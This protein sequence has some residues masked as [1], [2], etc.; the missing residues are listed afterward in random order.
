MLISIRS[1]IINDYFM[2]ICGSVCT[3]THSYEVLSSPPS[4][5]LS[6]GLRGGPP[7][8]RGSWSPPVRQQRLLPATGS[9][10]QSRLWWEVPR[11]NVTQRSCIQLLV[12]SPGAIEFP[13]IY[14]SF[15]PLRFVGFAGCNSGLVAL[16]N[17]QISHI[18]LSAVGKGCEVCCIDYM[19]TWWFLFL[20]AG[21]RAVWCPPQWQRP[22]V[23]WQETQRWVKIMLSLA[24]TTYLTNM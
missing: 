5:L 23:P 11:K 2:I 15:E 22:V 12:S 7:R 17:D 16:S 20:A 4:P 8:P 13:L 1:R 18:E 10:E 6:A 24:C 3:C 14:F 9:D 21:L 19:L